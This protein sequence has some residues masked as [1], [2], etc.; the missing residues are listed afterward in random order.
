MNARDLSATKM[1]GLMYDVLCST[2]CLR[3]KIDS[4]SHVLAKVLKT[5][6]GFLLPRHLPSSSTLHAGLAWA[7]IRQISISA[8]SRLSIRDTP[9]VCAI[10]SK[11]RFSRGSSGLMTMLRVRRQRPLVMRL[12]QVH[13]QLWPIQAR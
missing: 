3:L 13:F 7:I 5:I 10:F 4:S 8:R 1:R 6:N 11:T 12:L 2:R 9:P